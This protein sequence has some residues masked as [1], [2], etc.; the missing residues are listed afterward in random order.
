MLWDLDYTLLFVIWATAAVSEP[1][2]GT[3]PGLCCIRAERTAALTKWGQELSFSSRPDL[4]QQQ[5]CGIAEPPPLGRGEAEDLGWFSSFHD[6]LGRFSWAIT[7][8]QLHFLTISLPH[9]FLY[10]AGV[11]AHL[12]LSDFSSSLFFSLI[13]L[14]NF[15]HV[16]ICSS[17]L[18]LAAVSFPELQVVCMVVS[19]V[20][21]LSTNIPAFAHFC[22]RFCLPS[23]SALGPHVLG[24]LDFS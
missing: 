24:L 16:V 15:P 3:E 9:D 23:L 20:M 14:R 22:P 1:E 17:H 11:S 21:F 10:S 13:S 6:A 4:Q 18:C 2:Q 7:A 12:N 19:P 8:F 5:H